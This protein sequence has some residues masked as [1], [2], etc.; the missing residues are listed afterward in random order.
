MATK[1][2]LASVTQNN[3]IRVYDA[4]SHQLHRVISVDGNISSQPT[5]NGNVLSVTVEKD[6]QQFAHT[7]M[8]PNGNLVNK[9]PV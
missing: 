3:S 8:L 7:F 5:T 2:F 6:N 4:V 9:R 1:K